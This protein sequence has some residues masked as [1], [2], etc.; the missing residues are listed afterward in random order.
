M[1]A[2]YRLRME[3]IGPLAEVTAG[4]SVDVLV[5][6]DLKTLHIDQRFQYTDFFDLV[7]SEERG[8]RRMLSVEEIGGLPEVRLAQ[9]VYGNV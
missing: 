3:D 6:D 4:D 8:Q 1:S 9:E 5:N 7:L 2:Q